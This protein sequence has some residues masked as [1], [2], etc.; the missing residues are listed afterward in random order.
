MEIPIEKAIAISNLINSLKYRHNNRKGWQKSFSD[1]SDRLL[2]SLL[3]EVLRIKDIISDLQLDEP[4]GTILNRINNLEKWFEGPDSIDNLLRE[5]KDEFGDVQEEI[6]TIDNSQV[7]D[8]L[9]EFSSG[10]NRLIARIDLLEKEIRALDIESSVEIVESLL[11]G[12]F[13]S[14]AIGDFYREFNVQEITVE[15]APDELRYVLINEWISKELLTDRADFRDLYSE[16]NP[17]YLLKEHLEIHENL[18]DFVMGEVKAELPELLKNPKL[19]KA[20]DQFESIY[21]RF[22]SCSNF[23]ETKDAIQPFNV[24]PNDLLNFLENTGYFIDREKVEEILSALEMNRLV[25]LEGPPGSGKTVLAKYLSDFLLDSSYKKNSIVTVD[26]EWS[27]YDSIGGRRM[28]DG[29]FGPFL[30]IVTESVLTS[31]EN[32]GQHWLI[33]DEFNRGDINNYLSSFFAGMELDKGYLDIPWAYQN[34][35]NPHLRLKVPNFFRMIA[36]MN[37]YDK[38]QLFSV[39]EALKRRSAFVEILSPEGGTLEKLI[40]HR[41]NHQVSKYISSFSKNSSNGTLLRK[42]IQE[43]SLILLGLIEKVN[44]IGEGEAAWMSMNINISSAIIIKI[45]DST[46]LFIFKKVKNGRRNA[47][48]IIMEGLDNSFRSIIPRSIHSKNI[49]IH[50][51]LIQQ[52]FKED[53][54]PS[55][56]LELNR[57]MQK[58]RAI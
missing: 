56:F 32:D 29:V 22:E 15:G 42:C 33:L 28:I 39:P 21:K 40:S 55:T 44:I 47:N 38:D 36:T 27:T 11:S 37:S 41:K 2:N 50:Q 31:I 45:F 26:P 7:K 12:D 6:K 23:S 1:E 54:F 34:R 46:C 49:L 30:G 25:I 57:E 9:A 14:T 53:S 13:F 58:K 10:Q 52:V 3:S 17:D 19:I 43:A 5:L 20:P 51:R 48:A 16:L 8:L 4:E 24:D 35:E 18:Y